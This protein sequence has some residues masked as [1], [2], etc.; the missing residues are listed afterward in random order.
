MVVW[1]HGFGPLSRQN[2]GSVYNRAK[3]LAYAKQE[4]KRRR[5]PFR[6]VISVIHF[7][8][9]KLCLLKIPQF[10]KSPF[11]FKSIKRFIY[12]QGWSLHYPIIRPH[13]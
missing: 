12:G 4:A 5:G 8:P 11:D 6:A 1:P 9:C 2:D 10:P 7:P 13:L 3:L